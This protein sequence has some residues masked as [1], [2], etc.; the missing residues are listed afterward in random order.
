MSSAFAKLAGVIRTLLICTACLIAFGQ[1]A[2][3]ETLER[4]VTHDGKQR[5]YVLTAPDA[6][7]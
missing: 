3:A 7:G 5:T 2:L 4:T 6:A 1:D